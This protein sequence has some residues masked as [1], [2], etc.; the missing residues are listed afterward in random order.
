MDIKL[1][2]NITQG[3]LCFQGPQSVKMLANLCRTGSRLV[4]P[5]RAVEE[6]LERYREPLLRH[7]NAARS[8]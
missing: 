6:V 8:K 3:D 7:V 5:T 4:V 1:D 2:A